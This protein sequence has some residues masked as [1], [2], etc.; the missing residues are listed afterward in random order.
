MEVS[1]G[2]YCEATEKF[3]SGQTYIRVDCQEDGTWSMQGGLEAENVKICNNITEILPEDKTVLA[4]EIKGRFLIG[5]EFLKH[6]MFLACSYNKLS[7]ENFNP[8]DGSQLVCSIQPPKLNIRGEYVLEPP[9]T[10]HLLCDLQ[11]ALT[12]YTTWD[13][14]PSDPNY[15]DL[16]WQTKRGSEI[17][18]ETLIFGSNIK[19]WA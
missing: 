13:I 9:N 2:A 18:D 11:Y 5:Q 17:L 6:L 10:C 8:N 16:K 19:C 7:I 1:P 14:H 15:H 12:V 4:K 3:L